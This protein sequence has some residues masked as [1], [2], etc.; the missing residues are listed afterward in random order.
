ML[1]EGPPALWLNPPGDLPWQ[2]LTG[3]TPFVAFSQDHVSASALRATGAEVGFGVL[4]PAAAPRQ[5]LV[6][7]LPREKQRLHMLLRW[8]AGALAED[9]E[10]LLAGEIRAGAK[11]AAKRLSDHFANSRKID[12]ARHCVLY[13]AS[14]P[15]GEPEFR[16]QEQL[17]Y[18]SLDLLEPPLK[19]ASLPG[20]FAHG[21]LDE[22]SQ[23]LLETLTQQ[24]FSDHPRVLD[25]G[26]G[27]GV[28]GCWFLRR[29]PRADMVMA[30][31]SALALAA[32]RAT[33]AAA[34][35]NATLVASDGLSDLQGRFDLILSNPPFHV[36]HLEQKQL[37]QRLFAPLMDYLNP[38]GRC[39]MV[40][41]SH[42]NYRRWL[43]QSPG[44][45]RLLAQTS[46]F[47]VLCKTR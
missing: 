7:T 14:A 12:N 30:D 37:S 5:R 19:V 26:C 24:T 34:G 4:P 32:T 17:C 6:L 11:S 43:E 36:G 21:A 27:S 31:S 9:G 44:P 40:A 28:L 45:V 41:N 33:L 16:W 38:G 1:R 35:Q 42:L 47:Q 25:L 3:T 15:R 46:R 13:S 18:W 23:L 2:E 10:C 39:I 22:G 29:H 20:V 8:A